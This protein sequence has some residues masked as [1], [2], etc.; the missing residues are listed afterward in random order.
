[1]QRGRRIVLYRDRAP[2]TIENE[3]CANNEANCSSYNH[4]NPNAL[5]HTTFP[6]TPFIFWNTTRLHGSELRSVA[7]R[8][9]RLRTRQR[10]HKDVLHFSRV[11]EHHL[12]F[13]FCSFEP[14]HL[15]LYA[16]P[17]LPCFDNYMWFLFVFGLWFM[18]DICF[19]SMILIWWLG[20]CN[21]RDG[22]LFFILFFFVIKIEGVCMIWHCSGK[23]GFEFYLLF[24]GRA[25][26]LNSI[27]KMDWVLTF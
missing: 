14:S 4:L 11:Q 17:P 25:I 27:A 23:F 8:L 7:S 3:G 1:M 9:G 22:F 2:W 26:M 6:A 5:V 21:F 15:Q 20:C 16:F 13:P 24:C 10:A 18:F 19:V 12:V